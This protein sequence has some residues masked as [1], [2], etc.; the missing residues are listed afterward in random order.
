[1]TLK[2]WES[3][4]DADPA[5]LS[6]CVQGCCN[7]DELLESLG[8]DL[9]DVGGAEDVDGVDDARHGHV[10]LQLVDPLCSN[11]ETSLHQYHA[12][13]YVGCG[14]LGGFTIAWQKWGWYNFVFF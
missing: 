13:S 1:M 7:Q 11:F 9:E 3:H 14:M 12:C 2:T 6:P 10:A 8:V 4:D 5:G